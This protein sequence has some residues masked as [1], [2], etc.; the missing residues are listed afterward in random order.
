M[1]CSSRYLLLFVLILS[2]LLTACGSRSLSNSSHDESGKNPFYLG[3][4]SEYAVLG[5]EPAA[6]PSDKEIQKT[7]AT[8]KPPHIAPGS[9]VMVVQSG[10]MIPDSEMLQTL[11]IYYDVAVYSGVPDSSP[12][13][14]YARALRLAAARSGCDTILVYW[15]VLE[16]AQESH[17]SKALSWVPLIGAAIPDESQQMRIRLKVAVIDTMTGNWDSF[18]PAT[19]EDTASSSRHSRIKVDQRQVDILKGKAYRTAINQVVERYS[20]H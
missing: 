2:A 3:E 18:V 16:T 12:T 4:L 13:A 1:F 20:E 19:F 15:G 6:T 7:L 5:V 17:S 8:W 9:A 14:N 10:A 11:S